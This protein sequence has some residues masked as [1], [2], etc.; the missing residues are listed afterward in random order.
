[1]KYNVRFNGI[2]YEV[3]READTVAKCVGIHFRYS[4]KTAKQFLQNTVISKSEETDFPIQKM[5]GWLSNGLTWEIYR[6]AKLNGIVV[7]VDLRNY[8]EALDGIEQTLVS[9]I[10]HIIDNSVTAYKEVEIVPTENF[11]TEKE[12]IE[13]VNKE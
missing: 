2:P 7:E 10:Q 4:S 1:M 5:A 12:L 8:K 3:L 9:T 13:Y 6:I 11:V